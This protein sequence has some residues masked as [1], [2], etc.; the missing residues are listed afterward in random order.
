[1]V[2]VEGLPELK[3]S[4]DQCDRE[5]HHATGDAVLAAVSAGRFVARTRHR[6]EPRSPNGLEANTG[7]QIVSV[8]NE[9]TEGELFALKPYAEFVDK[10]T[11][12][13]P[14]NHPGTRPDPFMERASEEAERVLNETMERDTDRACARV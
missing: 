7:G 5:L 9:G 8:T 14:V 4:L 6:Y 12:P 11:R 13:H 10:G 1:M 2:T 3:A